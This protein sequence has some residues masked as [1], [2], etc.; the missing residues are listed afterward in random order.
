LARVRTA[1][2]RSMCSLG[3]R[4]GRGQSRC[5]SWR[6]GSR[7]EPS[8]RPGK[9]GLGG[10]RTDRD[11][12]WRVEVWPESGSGSFLA[13]DWAQPCPSFATTV[14]CPS[15]RVRDG[16]RALS[17][18]WIITPGPNRL[19]VES[20]CLRNRMRRRLRKGGVGG[21]LSAASLLSIWSIPTI[22]IANH[23]DAPRVGLQHHGSLRL[24]CEAGLIWL[25]SY[26]LFLG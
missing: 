9:R 1:H 22:A 15:S 16:R 5:R 3:P 8:L 25:L 18:A 23:F 4:S 17:E 24:R 6:Q 26:S 11:P 20:P 12:C 13:A 2:R 21:E 7:A 19:T 10:S 14:V